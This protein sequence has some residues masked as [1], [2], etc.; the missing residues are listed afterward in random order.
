MKVA[1]GVTLI[2]TRIGQSLLLEGPPVTLIDTGG[3]GSLR[4]ILRALKRTRLSAERVEQI[5]ITHSHADHI[6][7]A[8]E[9][10]ALSGARVLINKGDE[11][12]GTGRMPPYPPM[13]SGISGMLGKPFVQ[14]FARMTTFPP[15]EIDGYLDDGDSID[16]GIQVIAT[17]GHT[18]GHVSIYLPEQRLLHAADAVFNLTGLRPPFAIANQ[19]QRGV[20]ESIVR[21]VDEPFRRMT[22]GHGVPIFRGAHNR[23]A[24]L[25]RRHQ[26]RE[27]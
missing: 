11:E 3:P 9:L 20:Y 18:P 21:L 22:F 5:V 26:N 12:V 25:A 6:G 16:P 14:Q 15:V 23:L 17:P 1:P 2:H 4:R 27:K 13:P 24:R 10:R 8:A 7:T 19:N